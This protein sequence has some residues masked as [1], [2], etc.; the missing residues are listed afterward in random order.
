MKS[1]T[2][3]EEQHD[4][5][6]KPDNQLMPHLSAER[7]SQCAEHQDAEIKTYLVTWLLSLPLFE[8]ELLLL[9]KE[10]P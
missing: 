4:P 8:P 6:G 9:A 1:H 7:V 2:H 3:A 10:A 5:F